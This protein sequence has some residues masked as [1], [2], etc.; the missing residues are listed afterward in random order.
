IGYAYDVVGDLVGVTDAEGNTSQFSYDGVSQ[1]RLITDA[2]QQVTLFEYDSANNLIAITD[3]RGSRQEFSYDAVGRVVTFADAQVVADAISDNVTSNY[4]YD[5]DD[6]LLSVFTFLDETTFTYNPNGDV[7]ALVQDDNREFLYGRDRDG[8][9]TSI[10]DPLG[11]TTS[12]AY[13][14]RGYIARIS[15]AQG[16]LTEFQWRTDGR[17]LRYTFNGETLFFEADE[18]GRLENIINESDANDERLRISYDANGN[19]VLIARRIIEDALPPFNYAY[20]YDANGRLISYTTPISEQPYIYT[21]DGN[22]NIT[23]ITD[24]VGAMTTYTY[25]R[26]GNL[27]SVTDAQGFTTTYGYDAV[28]N[29]TDVALPSGLLLTYAY[30]ER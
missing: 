15:N 19:I 25:D 13:N 22:S 8:R 7:V 20:A 16:L 17:L 11:S 6:N 27:L 5:V 12:Y 2:N 3:A 1:L 21:Y 26:V 23:S 9:I 24:P 10:T 29:L 14:P 4:T 30:D 28:G 18:F